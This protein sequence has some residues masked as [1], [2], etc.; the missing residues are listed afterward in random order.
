MNKIFRLQVGSFKLTS[1]AYP[2]DQILA[3]QGRKSRRVLATGVPKD[4][5]E[6]EENEEEQHCRGIDLVRALENEE[7]VDERE[8]TR[9]KK[10]YWR[11][12]L[13]LEETTNEDVNEYED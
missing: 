6:E 5:N 11:P 7:E 10:T 1:E 4:K 13:W 8:K 9:K 3:M 2:K 12:D